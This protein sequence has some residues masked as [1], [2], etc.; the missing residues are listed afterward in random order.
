MPQNS[1]K[2]RHTKASNLRTLVNNSWVAGQESVSPPRRRL[3]MSLGRYSGSCTPGKFNGSSASPPISVM[4][5]DTDQGSD[6][7]T[8]TDPGK[9]N[10]KIPS[11]RI[12]ASPPA[13]QPP[14]LVTTEDTTVVGTLQ[15]ESHTQIIEENRL[16]LIEKQYQIL[17]S[18]QSDFIRSLESLDPQESEMIGTYKFMPLVLDENNKWLVKNDD[19]TLNLPAESVQDLKDRCEAAVN[20]GF[21]LLYDQLECVQLANDEFEASQQKEK[22]QVSLE[23]LLKRKV[24]TIVESIDLACGSTEGQQDEHDLHMYR[25]ID[26]LQKQKEV[27]EARILEI[28]ENHNEQMN[29]LKAR[30][31]EDQENHH[32]NLEELQ[33]M[34]SASKAQRDE[35][36][37]QLMNKD[38]AIESDKEMTLNHQFEELSAELV[39]TRKELKSSKDHISFL[40]SKGK[41]DSGLIKNLQKRVDEL[42]KSGMWIHFCIAKVQQAMDMHQT[43]PMSV[44]SVQLVLAD[45]EHAKSDIYKSQQLVDKLK[46]QADRDQMM[47]CRC[48]AELNTL[49]LKDT[50]KQ[51]AYVELLLESV[52]N[53]TLIDQM[54]QKLNAMGDQL[55]DFVGKLEL[56]MQEIRRLKEFKNFLLEENARIEQQRE[57]I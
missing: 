48:N 14:S 40:E 34:L 42:Q 39:R 28:T 3:S 17:K 35:L 57:G 49:R 8:K 53:D 31:K 50:E 20:S 27:M 2:I 45:L 41:V 11:P 16:R 1:T 5:S 13:A 43:S 22:L 7:E 19:L 54:R 33:E 12:D 52:N 32:S 15:G 51:K 21:M 38:N 37:R 55:S 44:S 24:C 36:E 9:S 26:E 6:D 56:H 25:K 10:S 47:L 30:F 29:R 46:T 18:L 23:G 4:D